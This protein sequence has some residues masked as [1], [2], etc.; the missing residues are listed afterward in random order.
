[1]L[2]LDDRKKDEAVWLYTG[3]VFHRRL[4]PKTHEFLYRIFLFALDIDRIEE[5]SSPLIGVERNRLYSFFAKD[6]FQ[7]VPGGTPREN[8]E[9]FLSSKGITRKPSRITLLT[10]LRFLG[11]TFN[12]ISVWF[13]EDESGEPIA[14]IAEVGNT[15]GELKPFLVPWSGKTF[16]SRQTKEFYVSPFSELDFEFHFRF[17]PLDERL[18]VYID[19]YRKK[20]KILISSLTGTR[21]RLT[22]T[23]LLQS[24][25]RFPF[26]TLKVIT[27]IHWQAL[28]LWAKRI[29][30]VTKEANPDQQTNLYN[31]KKI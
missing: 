25:A 20:E 26:I 12:P 29:P 4:W 15:F 7:A 1:M 30:F 19:E 5:I 6:H 17:H 21:Q 31:P 18:G 3:P 9:A 24:T 14:A 13:C 22:T 2:Q 16:E 8:A 28:K 23:S 27:L 11:Y 10:N